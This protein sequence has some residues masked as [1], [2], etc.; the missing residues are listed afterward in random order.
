MPSDGTAR[1]FIENWT[2]SYFK[3]RVLHLYTG[4]SIET[5]MDIYVAPRERMEVIDVHFRYGFLTTGR[6][7]W[8]I[9]GYQLFEFGREGHD[10]FLFDGRIF[11]Q[12]NREWKSGH[13]FGSEWKCHT[14]SEE[15]NNKNITIK[16]HPNS[17]EFVSPSGTSETTWE[18]SH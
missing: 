4:D 14:L 3:F 11:K 18:C 8:K 1:V 12:D 7:N 5:S 13:G 17:I 15:D 6:D 10:T 9:R 16:V 2:G